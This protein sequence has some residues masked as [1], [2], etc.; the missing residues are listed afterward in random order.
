MQQIFRI[1][2][3]HLSSFLIESEIKRHL[4][5]CLE[6]GSSF[7]SETFGS[8]DSADNHCELINYSLVYEGQLTCVVADKGA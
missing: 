8:H 5:T 7:L 1:F 6:E 2:L 3:Y 4:R